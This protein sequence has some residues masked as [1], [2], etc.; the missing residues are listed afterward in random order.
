MHDAAAITPLPTASRD[1]R[2]GEQGEQR[3]HRGDEQ[4]WQP[5][6]MRS[7]QTE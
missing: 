3:D 1:C 5:G 7:Q 6:P 2:S 4:R